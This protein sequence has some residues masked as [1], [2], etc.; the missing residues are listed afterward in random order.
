MPFGASNESP[1]LNRHRR[2]CV[3]VVTNREFLP[4]FGSP[5]FVSFVF[6]ALSD[7]TQRLWEQWSPNSGAGKIAFRATVIVTFTV[8]PVPSMGSVFLLGVL[9]IA[10]ASSRRA[11]A[12]Y[13]LTG[14]LRRS[15]NMRP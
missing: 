11:E 12:D 4:A 5:P 13:A 14:P 2:P 9:G 3:L 15:S 10:A 6:V 7:E 8:V 1:A